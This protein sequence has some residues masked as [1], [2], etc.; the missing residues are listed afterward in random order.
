MNWNIEVNEVTGTEASAIHA[1]LSPLD[2]GWSYRTF[3]L[4]PTVLSESKGFLQLLLD[5]P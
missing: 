2:S 3:Q 5:S 4:P 1:G